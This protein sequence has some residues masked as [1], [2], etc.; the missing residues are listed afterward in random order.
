MPDASDIDLATL[1]EPV[2]AIA[3][4]AGR[5]IMTVYT[6][7]FSVTEKADQSPITEADLASHSCILRGLAQLTPGIPIL[8]EEA[9]DVGFAERSRWEWLWLVDPLDGTREFIKRNDQFSVNIALIHRHEAVLG[10]ILPPVGEVCYYAWRG[11]GAF[12]QLAGQAPQRI[13]AAR[14]CHYPVRVVSSQGSYRTRRLQDYLGL[15]GPHRHISLGS[16]LKSCLIAEGGAD[17]YPRF[18][19]TGEWDTAAAQILVEEAGGYLTDTQF[20]PLR[21]NAR[22]ALINPDFFAFGDATRDWS[23]Y[24]PPPHHHPRGRPLSLPSH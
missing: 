19:P 16:A 17:L 15:L 2:Q 23:Q 22:P 21:Y 5:R 1:V 3:R 8:S 11:G 18:G 14:V 9:A 13:Q 24:I 12:K 7:A 20:R 4:E 6:G 10:L